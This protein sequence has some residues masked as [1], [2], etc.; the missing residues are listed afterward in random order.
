MNTLSLPDVHALRAFFL[1]EL[2][3]ALLNRFVHVF[4]GAAL[5]AGIA[6]LLAD[7]GSTAGETAPYLLIQAI[8]YLVP[9]FALLIGAGSAQS[10]QEERVFLFSQPAGRGASLLGKFLALWLLISLAAMLLALPSAIGESALASLGFLWLRAAGA[11]GVFLCLGLASGFSTNDRVKAHLAALCIWLVF[12]AGFDLA[13]LAAVHFPAVQKMP[14]LWAALL[15]ANPLDSLRIGA[16]LSL[17]RVP[18]DAS[19]APALAR[20]WLSHPGVC[21]TMVSAFWMTI[22][23]WWSGFRL[24]RARV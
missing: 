4:S 22:G 10:D 2:R 21:F 13:A 8:L 5:L 9:L 15:M 18:F 16:L 23:L 14:S 11:G 12:L 20:W 6:P 17:D 3:V 24:E 1:R 19:Q 7:S